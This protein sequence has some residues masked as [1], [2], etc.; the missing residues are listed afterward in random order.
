MLARMKQ[1]QRAKDY[2]AIG[3]IAR[4]LPPER[5]LLYTTDPDRILALAPSHGGGVDRPSVHAA[6]GAAGREQVVLALASEIDHLQRRDAVRVAAYAGAAA[7]YLEQFSRARVD[8]MPLREA[9]HAACALAERWLPIVPPGLEQH[10][11][12]AQ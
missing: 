9:H 1:T 11:A 3:E 4:L 10:H 6:R 12:D 8:E 2:P 5:E 7:R